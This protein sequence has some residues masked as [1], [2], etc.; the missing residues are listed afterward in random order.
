MWAVRTDDDAALGDDLVAL[1]VGDHGALAE[2][3]DVAE[4]L[5]SELVLAAL[6]VLDLVLDSELLED[7]EDA[8]RARVVQVV[9]RERRARTTMI[10][11][12]GGV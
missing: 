1:R 7:P 5:R 9:L 10:M 8:L 6:V 4:L 12:T 2:R 11:V 3:V